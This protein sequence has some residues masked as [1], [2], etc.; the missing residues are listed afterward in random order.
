VGLPYLGPYP[1]RGNAPQHYVFTLIATSLEVGA[2]PPGLDKGAVMEALKGG[3]TL[4]AASLVLRF[5]H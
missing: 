5:N 3:K 4:G 2:L 1:P